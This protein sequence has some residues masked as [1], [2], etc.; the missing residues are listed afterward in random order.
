MA[1]N[2]FAFPRLG[3]ISAGLQLSLLCCCF[4]GQT[5]AVA[6]GGLEYEV[7]AAF[8]LNFTK[9]V[10]WPPAAFETPNS[11]FT[12]C[13]LGRDPFGHS[14]DYIL[15]GESVSGRKLEVRRIDQLPA[16]QTCQVLF[17][18]G[19]FKEIRRA[20]SDIGGTVL[21]V[22]EGEAFVNEGGIIA[23]VVDNRR[24]RFVI[25]QRAAQRSG[26]KLSSRLLGVAKLVEK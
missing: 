8:L 4:P 12:L 16:R 5:L 21:T 1:R 20:L 11:P 10:E 13:I 2:R 25:N 18:D 19:A 15:Q 23:F 3:R 17:T 7:K 24:V 26:L 22:G 6:E 9:F 14:I